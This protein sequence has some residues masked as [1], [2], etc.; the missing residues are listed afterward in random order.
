MREARRCCC[1]VTSGCHS[2]LLP[3]SRGG[4]AVGAAALH[5]CLTPCI[6]RSC[7]LRLHL[8]CSQNLLDRRAQ[9]R[10]QARSCCWLMWQPSRQVG[11]TPPV[12]A[13]VGQFEASVADQLLGEALKTGPSRGRWL[14]LWLRQHLRTL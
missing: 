7:V 8:I 6:R 11:L 2:A 12:T 1:C 9:W 3:S 10:R 4:L 14:D 5:A 13:G